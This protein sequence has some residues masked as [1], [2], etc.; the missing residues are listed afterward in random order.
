M[1]RRVAS[2][3]ISQT[4]CDERG[5]TV[6]LSAV[7][8]AA[9]MMISAMAIDLGN[10]MQSRRHLQNATDGASLAAADYLS[11]LTGA[12]TPA[13][14]TA[15]TDIAKR[16]TELNGLSEY[17]VRKVGSAGR[18]TENARLWSTECTAAPTGFVV[19]SGS[20]SC[21]SFDSLTNPARVNVVTPRT[22][23]GTTFARVMGVSRL[24]VGA[25]S[26]S[27]F[28][29]F[30]EVPPPPPTTLAP[31]PPPPAP[32]IPT[33]T[34]PSG[35]LQILT[36]A[37]TTLSETV[38]V[39]TSGVTLP[40]AG[41]LTVTRWLS[42][43]GAFD[44]SA[45]TPEL[46][47][48]WGVRVGATDN[49]SYWTDDLQDNIDFAS[50]SFSFPAR[51]VPAGTIQ[52]VHK[53]VAGPASGTVQPLG[54]CY[55]FVAGA[56]PPVVAPTVA[57]TPS[58][59]CAANENRYDVPNA[60]TR[61]VSNAN[62]KIFTGVNVVAGSFEVTKYMSYDG[63]AG[64]ATAAAELGEIW[65]I[66]IGG[67]DAGWTAE[68]PDG[69]EY[70]QV[71]GAFPAITISAG[72]IEIIHRSANGNDPRV[73]TV[74]PIGFCYKITTPATAGG[75][76]G[77]GICLWGPGAAFNG[78][79]GGGATNVTNG[80]F[81]VFSTAGGS[82][83]GSDVGAINVTNGKAHLA[84]GYN[85]V[86]I[87]ANPRLVNQGQAGITDPL[88][89]LPY[90]PFPTGL[91]YSGW[92]SINATRTLPSGVYGGVQLSDSA[93]VTL[94]PG[95]FGDVQTGGGNG[96][97]I[98]LNPGIYIITGR[99]A[100]AAV[101]DVVGSGV[102]LFFTC[103]TPQ[104]PRACN[105]GGEEGGYLADGGGGKMAFNATGHSGGTYGGLVI[106]ADRNNTREFQ[107]NGTMKLQSENNGGVYTKSA[108]WNMGGGSGNDIIL[109]SS[110]MVGKLMN[111]GNSNVNI[112]WDD[113]KNNGGA[114]ELIRAASTG[115]SGTVVTNGAVFNSY[116]SGGGQ[117]S[118]S[119]TISA[120]SGTGGSGSGGTAT[121][122]P[123]IVTT[124][125]V[126]TTLPRVTTT[127]RP[128]TT[129]YAGPPTTPTPSSTVVK[130]RRQP[131]LQK[132]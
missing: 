30:Q 57:P 21:V 67:I 92:E 109:P 95:V 24:K 128:P 55:T 15:A 17:T 124:V 12:V 86:K 84:G 59:T 108:T 53:S 37:G 103:G 22:E 43:D 129:I 14:L 107:V 119:Y 127:T 114:A 75:S 111:N 91:P 72:Q 27:S 13:D 39:W 26:K 94:N 110:F 8:M 130:R 63:Y 46:G 83:G 6:V 71:T 132:D 116:Q 49:A 104:V 20:T 93:S 121:T 69:V 48:I 41:T 42:Y 10:A 7:V 19:P 18:V 33:L 100:P 61:F 40:S 62:K 85:N 56:A 70:T 52:F 54:I 106:F 97:R 80:N 50:D 68:L 64:R 101:N 120:G 38:P 35:T 88:A 125:R 47:E 78:G 44:R 115:S 82:V 105:A 131:V 73:G 87:N 16:Y 11:Q 98:T 79:G 51:S 102:L 36:P 9:L 4:P 112:N 66:R 96:G 31:P 118:A 45:T 76:C 29:A 113:S 3:R 89:S 81:T 99:F 122:L 34:C 5:A 77:K 123:I 23:I 1:K 60:P 126:T 25:S 74:R 32:G 28:F 117:D 90:P 65:G 2:E 58:F